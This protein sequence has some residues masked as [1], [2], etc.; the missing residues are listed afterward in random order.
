MIEKGQEFP[1]GPPPGV[2]IVK[3]AHRNVI[4]P[5][6]EGRMD[7]FA[8]KLR[9]YYIRE[10]VIPDEKIYIDA[11]RLRQ[12]EDTIEKLR[13]NRLVPGNFPFSIFIF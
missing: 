9:D 11:V 12:P 5:K 8:K 2:N 1:L 10:G 7:I 13:E 3:G 4:I 6:I